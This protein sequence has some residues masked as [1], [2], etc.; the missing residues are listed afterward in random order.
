MA[1]SFFSPDQFSPGG[2][3]RAHR[4]KN[5]RARITIQLLTV[6]FGLLALDIPSRKYLAARPPLLWIFPRGNYLA[7]RSLFSLVPLL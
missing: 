3:L 2:L 4:C 1:R 7:A 6:G 5:L